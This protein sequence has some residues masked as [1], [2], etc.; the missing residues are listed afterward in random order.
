MRTST[1]RPLSQKDERAAARA[2]AAHPKVAPHLAGGRQPVLIAAAHPSRTIDEARRA[3][4]GVHD[5]RAGGTVLAEIDLDRGKVVAVGRSPAVLQLSADEQKQANRLAGA[6]K[7]VQAF[8][9]KEKLNPLTRLYFPRPS[10]VGATG[11]GGAYA[12]THRHA[13]VDLTDGRVKQFLSRAD[14]TGDTSDA[15]S[16]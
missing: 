9:G 16:G 4:V 1:S 7:R 6:D 13:I 8:L 10:A 2:A 11:S 14:F 15:D 3:V 5:H 12:P